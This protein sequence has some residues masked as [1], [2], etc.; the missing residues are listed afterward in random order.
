MGLETG[1]TINDLNESWPLGTDPKSQGDDHIRLCK[2][3][4]K[5][6]VLSTT[7]GGTISGDVDFAGDVSFSG[8]VSGVAIANPNLIINGGFDV[9]QR[10]DSFT[11][12]GIP[13]FTAD[14]WISPSN[15][16]VNKVASPFRNGAY[17]AQVSSASFLVNP[18]ELQKTGGDAPFEMSSSYTLQFKSDQQPPAVYIA[19]RDVSTSG[20]N[21]KTFATIFVFNS[22]PITGGFLYTAT[23]TLTGGF[24]PTN[25]SL[26][27][28][29]QLGPNQVLGDV[30]LE[31]GSVAT[32][33]FYE[34]Y[35]TTL[36][37]CQRYYLKESPS[38]V[39]YAQSDNGTSLTRRITYFMPVTMRTTPT[40]TVTLSTGTLGTV[41]AYPRSID[42]PGT[43][44]TVGSTIVT[45]GI[46]ADAEL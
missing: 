13:F 14:R 5:N 44:E 30:K 36:A 18:I 31:Q 2:R 3:V 46:T 32:P 24:N 26:S 35:G 6:D 9:W 42:I 10:G 37:K 29:I 34:D 1:N 45:S 21:E 27:V 23:F 4:F 15:T 16:T 28:V 22:T 38:L 19:G 11:Y 8:N 39:G 43:S 40:V 41:T 20:T 17:A 7:N 33:W 12:L 25:T